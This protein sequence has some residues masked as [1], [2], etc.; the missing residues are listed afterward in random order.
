MDTLD[1][2][3]DEAFRSGRLHALT[4]FHRSE[5]IV[6]SARWNGPMGWTQ[7]IERD[8]P[9][10]AAIR[11]LTDKP[12][13]DEHGQIPAAQRKV[14]PKSLTTHQPKEPGDDPFGGL[15]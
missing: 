10:K 8:D 4:I 13:R 9:A 2:L 12:N 11:A 15:V 3:L 5:G 1:K 7:A 6:A 14:Q